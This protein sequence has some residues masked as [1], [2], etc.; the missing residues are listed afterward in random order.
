M[1]IEHLIEIFGYPAVLILVM[2][3]SMGV[4]LP[5]ETALLIASAFSARYPISS[6]GINLLSNLNIWDNF[7][8]TNASGRKCK[9]YIDF[10]VLISSQ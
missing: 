8:N 2:G 7:Y 5:G 6:P 4:P 10:P 9:I 3:E 1:H